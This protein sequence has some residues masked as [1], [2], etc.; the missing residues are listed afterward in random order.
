MVA[1]AADLRGKLVE[2]GE[3]RLAAQLLEELDGE[4][5]TVEIAREI[6]EE[7]FESRRASSV[8][9]RVQSEARHSLESASCCTEAFYRKDAGEHGLAPAQ[10]DVGRGK[11]QGAP[12]LRAV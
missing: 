12:A 11:S 2:R 10:T 6:E 1:V 7:C 4:A 8:H 9:G 5:A 3:M